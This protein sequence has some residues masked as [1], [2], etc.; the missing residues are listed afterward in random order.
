MKKNYIMKNEF[1]LTQIH[2]KNSL[3]STYLNPSTR[4]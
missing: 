3:F 2:T 1:K 4:F